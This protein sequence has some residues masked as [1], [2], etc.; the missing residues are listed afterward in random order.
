MER[1]LE[2]AANHPLLSGALVAVTVLVVAYEIRQRMKAGTDVGPLEAVRMINDGAV[3]LDTRSAAQFEKGH[4]VDAHNVPMSDL[5]ARAGSLEKHKD[6]QLVVYCDSG[7]SSSKAVDFLR[8]QGFG[9]VVGL[10]GGLAGWRQ[11]NLPVVRGGR[12]KGRRKD[13]E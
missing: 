10:R 2:Y 13:G 6:A 5:E 1:L 3:V 8:R 7:M 9:K 11:E 12:G 4:I